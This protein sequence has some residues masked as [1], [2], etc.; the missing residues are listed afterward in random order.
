MVW[1]RY[2]SDMI[3]YSDALALMLGEAHALGSESVAL[4]ASYRRVLANDV[5][6]PLAL[7]SFDNAAMDGYALLAGGET[8]AAGSTFAVAAM[9]AAGDGTA[10]YPSTEACEIA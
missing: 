3:S 8:I 1:A 5:R 4:E 10:S 7:P 2:A 9:Q 6:S